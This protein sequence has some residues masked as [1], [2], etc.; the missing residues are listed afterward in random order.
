MARLVLILLMF[1]LASAAQSKPP[2]PPEPPE[3]DATLTEEK[4]YTFNPIEANKHF[5]IGNFYFKKGSYK[6]AALRYREAT[7]WNPMMM[8]AYLK[9]GESYERLKDQKQARETYAKFLELAPDAKEA[10]SI[11]RKLAELERS[12]SR[13]P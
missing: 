3:E 1:G 4:T 13:Q 10:G 12:E 2:E 6:A 7:R 9:L 11:R 8:E 5:K